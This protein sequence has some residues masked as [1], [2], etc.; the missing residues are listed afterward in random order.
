MSSQMSM[1]IKQN[2]QSIYSNFM[3]LFNMDPSVSNSLNKNNKIPPSTAENNS[4][5]QY[6]SLLNSIS[7]PGD[8][9]VNSKSNHD[10]TEATKNS[11]NKPL[12]NNNAKSTLKKSNS[13]VDLV[14]SSS[15]T[16]SKLMTDLETTKKEILSL[17]NE[18]SN[19]LPNGNKV[20]TSAKK[21]S[22][23][24]TL[25]SS[26]RKKSTTSIE[27][28]NTINST[29]APATNATSLSKANTAA[30]S[31]PSVL[32]N[33]QNPLSLLTALQF[34]ML[35]NSTSTTTNVTPSTTVNDKKATPVNILP[36]PTLPA[37]STT[38]VLP[39][40]NALTSL[41]SSATGMPVLPNTTTGTTT[42]ALPLLPSTSTLPL[43]QPNLADNSTPSV[44]PNLFNTNGL[45]SLPGLSA[46]Q[47]NTMTSNLGLPGFPTNNT[48]NLPPIQPNLI[49]STNLPLLNS[50]FLSSTLP[51]FPSNTN[52]SASTL[53]PLQPNLSKLTTP[54]PPLIN[55]LFN[56]LLPQASLLSKLP[57]LTP[58]N[59]SEQILQ[60][61]AQLNLLLQQQSGN[62]SLFML[63]SQNQFNPLALLMNMIQQQN[64]SALNPLQN[65]N[66]IQ[67]QIQQLLLMQSLTLLQQQQQQQQ[68]QQSKNEA[69]SNNSKEAIS[70]NKIDNKTT[71]SNSN[72]KVDK[73]TK[74]TTIT[75][76][77]TIDN[78]PEI[79][80]ES[81]KEGHP[82][83]SEANLISTMEIEV[84]KGGKEKDESNDKTIKEGKNA[85]NVDQQMMKIVLSPPKDQDQSHDATTL[86][87]N[88]ERVADLN[89]ILTNTLSST[90]EK[91]KNETNSNSCIP[92]P[93]LEK[94]HEENDLFNK[95]TKEI[96]VI[97]NKFLIAPPSPAPSSSSVNE[98]SEVPENNPGFDLLLAP[99][100]IQSVTTTVT[101]T[102]NSTS[103]VE[104]T[105]NNE[106]E[107]V[108]KKDTQNQDDITT[109]MDVDY[110]NNLVLKESSKTCQS[111]KEICKNAKE[112]QS[113]NLA[114]DLKCESRLD[115]PI[116]LHS[117]DSHGNTPMSV[118]SLDES[119]MNVD[120]PISLDSINLKQ[121]SSKPASSLNPSDLKNESDVQVDLPSVINISRIK[122][123][124]N[125]EAKDKQE[126]QSK[127]SGI[128]EVKNAVKE[129]IE[130]NATLL[131]SK[132]KGV[133]Q[134]SDGK[135][136]MEDEIKDIREK[137]KIEIE[138][139]KK[140]QSQNKEEEKISTVK[141]TETSTSVNKT[142]NPFI[143]P[144]GSAAAP[145][146]NLPSL[147]LPNL[148]VPPIPNPMNSLNI[149]MPN[150]KPDLLSNPLAPNLSNDLLVSSLNALNN[151]TTSLPNAPST[152]KTPES[153]LSTSSTTP[154]KKPFVPLATPLTSS[155]INP[156]S[157]TN[158]TQSLLLGQNKA[159]INPLQNIF[160]NS[161]GD[162]TNFKAPIFPL[163][164]NLLV[165][166]LNTTIKKPIKRRIS[167][168]S[169]E[170]EFSD[171]KNDM[172]GLTSTSP[173]VN[174]INGG[175]RKRGKYETDEKKRNV[176]ERN[177]QAAL[178]CRQ[179]KKQ[180]LISL[181]KQIDTYTAENETL[182][183][184][185]ILLQEE[186]L[187]LKA[188]LLTHKPCSI[189]K[190]NDIINPIPTASTP[191][192]DLTNTYL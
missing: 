148:L 24:S 78:T 33:L 132:E 179:K 74:K 90:T 188:L 96:G 151:S 52:S 84:D 111:P 184:Q 36:N 3:S 81:L 16:M 25:S 26:K 138:D 130:E 1:D 67:Q 60:A 172:E 177:R 119:C 165:P 169:S 80:I 99:N 140:G 20:S 55:P 186:I 171:E 32:P 104:K 120:T 76:D 66:L 156:T 103:K 54:L 11:E 89:K 34:P 115:T 191:M 168:T 4:L 162:L 21:I 22:P 106:V 39:N 114:I 149:L 51:A 10:T 70:K 95:L 154:A 147:F 182:Q 100:A 110:L 185:A 27:N 13:G 161:L 129:K 105:K 127:V 5:Q 85:V 44:L 7:L 144:Q 15:D 40:L 123:E 109:S 50:N 187:T 62:L 170:S 190:N 12:E 183:N 43:L 65:T 17:K 69:A 141:T 53:P 107:I 125:E 28:S 131:K 58:S 128:N 102:E 155:L 59:L 101:I 118:N 75:V 19:A 35:S 94:I 73:D 68:Q 167:Q 9:A 108:N 72:S 64:A 56:S 18:T 181:Q 113:S 175:S 29:I 97:N 143:L 164:M 37:T 57:A 47:T 189:N 134:A 135:D 92:S 83:K 166:K 173:T 14:F 61:Q 136:P 71:E 192:N 150:L 49:N 88:N 46:L 146:K 178:K 117:L 8:K 79:T 116:S 41:L 87:M 133:L 23:S 45:T 30:E 31:A 124:K 160:A 98:N 77:L 163:N 137:I 42:P 2:Y 48:S 38:S 122:Q 159:P 158:Y 93:R 126:C 91:L 86:P 63:P 145:G 174:N 82:S 176:L 139:E 157:A 180:W 121:D 152:S 112:M 153:S 6:L 142:Q